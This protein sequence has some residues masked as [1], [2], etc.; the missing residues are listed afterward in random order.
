MWQQGALNY[1]LTKNTVSF[2]PDTSGE[3]SPSLKHIKPLQVFISSGD[4]FPPD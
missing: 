2:R 1:Q 3:E 4:Q